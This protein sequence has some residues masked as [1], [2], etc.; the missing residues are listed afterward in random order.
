MAVLLDVQAVEHLLGDQKL[1]GSKASHLKES[2]AAHGN[3]EWTRAYGVARGDSELADELRR[4]GFDIA[5]S[6]GSASSRVRRGLEMAVDAMA[7]CYGSEAFD[8][9]VLV[10]EVDGWEPLVAKLKA[11]G[12]KIVAVGSR[13][14][15]ADEVRGLFDT[16]LDLHELLGSGVEDTVDTE[17]EPSKAPVFELL[18]KTIESLEPGPSGVL[19][20]SVLKRAMHQRY[21]EFDAAQ[22]GYETFS[23][24]LED[25][26][27]YRVIELGRDDRSGN[28]YVVSRASSDV[29]P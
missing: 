7:I 2:L 18:T 12:K 6:S 17:I 22:H 20:G 29:L 26:D 23:D 4:A 1:D 24:L 3:L 5:V 27:R 13:T 15:V 28:Y 25:A 16:Y 21:P 9:V 14:T 8:S 10:G 11:L 19:W